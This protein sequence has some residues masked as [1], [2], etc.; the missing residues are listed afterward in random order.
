VSV[1]VNQSLEEFFPEKH[2]RIIAEPGRYYVASAFTLVTNVH[3]KKIILNPTTEEVACS[4]LY[5]N[6]GVYASFNCL[7][8]D[9]QVV[10]PELL[11]VHSETEKTVK[12]T[13]FGPTCDALDEIIVGAD[14]PE[15]IDLGDFMYFH[16]MGAYTIP[17][18]SPFNGF[19]LPKV[20]HFIERDMWQMIRSMIPVEADERFIED[21]IGKSIEVISSSA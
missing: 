7:L 3:S 11:K 10:K 21:F 13:I 12:T 18:A 1:I 6:D 14:M 20:Y 4:M 2:V 16:N 9:H 15:S 17:V 8:Y 19:P 5:I